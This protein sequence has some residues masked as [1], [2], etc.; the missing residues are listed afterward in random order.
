MAS[1]LAGVD[2]D[3]A[4]GTVVG[5]VVNGRRV[6]VVRGADGWVMV[7]DACPHAICPFSR[8]GEVV[9]GG[10]TLSC[11]CHG[12]RF[13]LVTGEV[14]AGPAREALPVTPLDVADGVLRLPR[15]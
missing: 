13:D 10:R 3:V 15:G 11:Y 12:S 14:L 9:D 1:E 2:P 5:A 4:V 7:P 6:A 8:D